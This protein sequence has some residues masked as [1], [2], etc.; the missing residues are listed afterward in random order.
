MSRLAVV[1]PTYGRPESLATCLAALAAQSRPPDEVVVAA[2]RGDTA[3]A[4]V[5]DAAAIPARLVVVDE[6]GVL[7]AMIAGVAAS[8]S[9]IVCFTDDDAVPPPEWVARLEGVF[10][11]SPLIGGAGGRDVLVDPDG[12]TRDE[13]PT[14]DVGRLLWFGRH[15]GAHHRGE[16]PARD[17]AFLK[18]VNSAYRRE[19][20]ALPT[21]LRGSG[22]QAHFEVAVGRWAT[23]RGWRLVYDPSLCVV[24]RPAARLGDDQRAGPSSDAVADAAYNLVVAIGGLRGLVRV[25]Y[26]VLAGDRGSPGALR[27]LVALAR[28]DRATA[29]R[30]VPSVRGTLA[31]GA[32]ILARRGVAYVRFDDAA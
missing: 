24:H 3:V 29:A 20:L 13:E 22:A 14:G 10:G 26:A 16:G 17:V 2:R 32:A 1:V 12:T 19:A 30:L 9:P 28:G 18:G 27:A 25:A 4:G 5:V 31:G 8:S 15:V 11:A 21:G 7:A 6:P 23:S